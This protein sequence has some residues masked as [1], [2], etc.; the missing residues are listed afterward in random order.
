MNVEE[1]A[2]TIPHKENV[3]KASKEPV[4]VWP[5]VKA[6]LDKAEA[7]ESTRDAAQAAM[8]SS[9][10]CVTLA[11]YLNTQVGRVGKVDERFKVPLLILAAEHAKEDGGV[12]SIYDPSEGRMYFETDDDEFAFDVEKE[13]TVD[14]A[15]VADEEVR[16]YQWTGIENETWA[17]DKLMTYLDVPIDDY[18][19]DDNDEG[20]TL[21]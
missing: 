11:N 16:G 1:L 18:L 6:A 20:H 15:R 13:W 9:D 14:W 4:A 5:L 8:K 21:L 3:T 2:V 17:L 19:V 7:D 12:D 10:G